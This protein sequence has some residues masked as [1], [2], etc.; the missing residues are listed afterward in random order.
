MTAAVF[1][2]AAFAFYEGLRADNSKTY[3]TANKSVYERAVREPMRALLDDL[4]PVFDAEP[5]LFRPYRDVRFSKDK[6]PY[7]THQGGFLHSRVDTTKAVHH[8]DHRQ[9]MRLMIDLP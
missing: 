5:A 6:S 3:W 9:R 2:D 4:A 1:D 7:K 8:M